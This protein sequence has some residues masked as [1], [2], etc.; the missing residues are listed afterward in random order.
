MSTEEIGRR[1][2]WMIRAME[3]DDP[4][5]RYPNIWFEGM[6]RHIIAFERVVSRLRL[7][8]L[9]AVYYPASQRHLG[10]AER[11]AGI[12]RVAGLRR[13][14]QA[15]FGW[16]D[17]ETAHK[18]KE[19]LGLGQ[20]PRRVFLCC[21]PGWPGP[22]VDLFKRVFDAA[23][24]EG[25]EPREEEMEAAEAIAA[26]PE[27][28]APVEVVAPESEAIAPELSGGQEE[29]SA[30]DADP[31]PEVIAQQTEDETAPEPGEPARMFAGV[32]YSGDMRDPR[33]RTW[34]AVA[35]LRGDRLRV[36]RLEATG[37]YGLQ[38][39]LRDPGLSLIHI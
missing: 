19:P 27:P 15:G 30:P 8:D 39:Y 11:F 28:E 18:F 32:D 12:S 26:A 21:D 31:T 25:W 9:V 33:D 35:E 10:R 7:G 3:W 14:D 22:E 6:P 29:P 20:Q 37:R 16:I 34:L 23:I 36:T 4:R 24:A 5:A 1:S 2:R 13:A 38:N 17:L